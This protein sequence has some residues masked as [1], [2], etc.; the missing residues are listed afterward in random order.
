LLVR[1]EQLV[2]SRN[3]RVIVFQDYNKGVLTSRMIERVLDLAQSRGIRTAVDPKKHLFFA[4]KGV[5]LFKPN[6]KEVRDSVPFAVRPEVDSLQKAAD[7]L[8]ERLQNRMTMLTLSEKGLYLDNGTDAG[9][10][11]PTIP[12]NI[13]DVSGA[14]DTV[15]SVAALC[16]A[17]GLDMDTMAVLSNLAGGQVCEYPG[18]VPVRL[19]VLAA[20][21][22]DYL[23]QHTTP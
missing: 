7:Y 11:Y 21:Y 17:A 4:Y 19:D 14:G 3:V 23:T 22:D 1:V 18:V 8:R 16:L 9:R 10:L 5:D 15:I 2:E 13:S 12:R 6:L 20:E